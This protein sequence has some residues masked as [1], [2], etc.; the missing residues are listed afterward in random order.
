MPI[1]R[2]DFFKLSGVTTAGAFFGGIPF[3]NGC[4]TEPAKLIG[5]KETTSICP[6]CTVGCGLIVSTRNGK[7]INI[8][9]DSDHPIN[10]GALC[11][12]GSA[13]Y[14]VI[15]TV[16]RLDSVRY[17]PPYSNDWKVISWDDAI[18]MIAKRIKKARDK[19]F[20]HREGKYV[21][22]R[23]DGLVGLGGLTL[24]NEE[25]YIWSKFA[26]I[27]GISYLEH[28]TNILQSS[29]SVGLEKSLG[30]GAMTNHLI[31]IQ[32]ADVI[33]IIGSNPA[34]SHPVSFKYI[35]KAKENGGRLI[36]IDPRFTRTSSLS[37][38]YSS[39]RPGTDISFINGIINYAIQNNQ[40]HKDYVVEYTNASF[41]VNPRF[42]FRSG[43]FRGYDK[44]TRR[45]SER[46]F[47]KYQVDPRGVPYIDKTLKD[48]NCVYQLMKKFFS[49]YTPETVS[50]I[51]GCS[52]STYNKIAE[53]YTSTFKPE[54]AATIIYGRG[55]IQHTVGTQTVRSYT[56]LQLLLGNIG[57]AGGGINSIT[58]ESNI[59]GA[60][61]HCLSSDF[62]PGY[63]EI[64]RRASDIILDDYL[65]NN[66]PKTND[67]RSVNL[68][69]NKGK[70]LI[71]LLKAFYGDAATVRNDFCYDWIPKATK[72]CSSNIMFRDIKAGN[73]K[74][75]IIMGSNPL[76]GGLNVYREAKALGKLD[77]LV[78]VDSEE[79]DTSVFW[80]R[81]K[82][83]PEKIKTEVFL[84]PTATSLEK[85]GSI[86]NLS[87]WV[88]WK[89]KVVNAPGEAK[90]ALWILDRLFRGI[91]GLYLKDRKAVF[92]DPIINAYWKFT[93][94]GEDHPDPHLV[95]KE[96]NGFKWKNKKQIKSPLKLK[97]DGSTVCGNWLYSGSY[98]EEGNMMARRGLND[99][100]NRMGMYPQWAWCWP[101]NTRIIYN[102]AGV[103][104]KGRP[105]NRDK[106]VVK[107]N[108]SE[109]DGDVIDGD[110]EPDKNYPFIMLPEGTGRIFSHD[111]EDG[112]FPE[113][114][115]PVESPTVNI[116]NI[117]G[118]SPVIALRTS[119]KEKKLNHKKK[120]P[121]V[122]TIYGIGEHLYSSGVKGGLPWLNELMPDMFCEISPLLAMEKGIENGDRIKVFSPRGK[123]VTYALVTE[124]IQPWMINNRRVEMVGLCWHFNLGFASL[125][126]NPSRLTPR[127]WDVNTMIHELKAFLVDI[128]KI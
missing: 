117:Q 51:T 72:L 45:Y 121:Y 16:N 30:R 96:I 23:T 50:Q 123:I 92:P 14:Q 107:W 25:C 84:L 29:R 116:M 10:E 57:I 32:H 82:S 63:L 87:R 34:E 76:I 97:D 54:R 28:Q 11:S 24:N 8:E 22:N 60:T 70:Y 69:Q 73:H 18:E 120:Y 37:D 89:Y 43:L 2:R 42:R 35:G 40:I 110:G 105:W 109:W 115:E 81:P 7:I 86:S 99:A 13:F 90:D 36:S 12:K 64:P 74:G 67:P 78:M 127:I 122:A 44:T 75:A 111:M 95:A 33:L 77:W 83:N 5:T 79:N 66:T 108:G 91:R 104:R 56:I 49:R 93:K 125:V 55:A 71:S 6:Y 39:L 119:N 59:H 85:E 114:Y 20:I 62:L 17:R 88:Q 102:R 65:K 106:W 53:L 52:L 94:D 19:T 118:E 124:R 15:D 4:K 126:N 128:K 41:L 61:D 112:P 98:I 46:S 27:L 68:L 21:V 26:R 103:D 58:G 101:L 1:T 31:D 3:L 48:P 9:G 113:H 80:K 100:P 38:I 47:W